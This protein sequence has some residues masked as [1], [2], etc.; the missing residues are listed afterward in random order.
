MA[1]AKYLGLSA[2]TAWAA[3]NMGN[4]DPPYCYYEGGYLQFNADGSNTGECGAGSGSYKDTCL[5][6]GS[7]G[8]LHILRIDFLAMNIYGGI[9]T[10]R[11]AH[12]LMDKL[13]LTLR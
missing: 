5:C 10:Y 12:L 9:Y 4:M 2:T 8:E 6:K 7:A 1:A 11:V 13:L 3:N